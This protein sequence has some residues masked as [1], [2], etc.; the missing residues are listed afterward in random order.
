[1]QIKLD[2]SNAPS[3]QDGKKVN[4]RNFLKLGAASIV[5]LE[6]SRSQAFS[7]LIADAQSPLLFDVFVYGS[8]P[9]GVAAAWEAA[10]SGC[11][12]LLACPQNHPG[13]MLASGLCAMDTGGHGNLFGGFMVEYLQRVNREYQRILGP[14]GRKGFGGTEPSIA[15]KVFEDILG[16]QS[17][18]LQFFRRHHLLDAQVKDS[19]I[20]GVTLLS[21]KGDKI[22]VAARTF[23]DATYEADLA[24]CAKVPYRVG[25]EAREEYG[26]SKAGIYYMNTHTGEEIITPYSGESSPAI[27]A[28]CARSIF[29]DDSAHLV[30][31]EKPKTFEQH[32]PDYLPLLLDFEQRRITS[33]DFGKAIP[34]HK[35]EM[36]GRIDWQ[37][38]TNC[39]G[40]SWPWPEAQR[41]YREQLAQF[42][43]DHV[44]GLIWFLQN[45][46]GVPDHISRPIR[47]IGLHDSEFTD[48]GHWPWQI[49]VRQ[50]R[51]IE[52]RAI[53][54]Q[55]NFTPDPKTNKTPQ[56]EHPVAL[57]T[58]TFDV[59][60][61]QDRRF[62]VD[63]FMEGVLWYGGSLKHDKPTSPGQIPYAALLPKQLDNLLVP[64][65]LSS[66]HM[67]MAVVRMEPVWMT[68][69]HVAGFAAAMAHQKGMDV[70]NL[71]PTT[72]PGLL[73]IP[74]DPD[75]TPGA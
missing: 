8:T 53:V 14:G 73:K 61:C 24:A 21:P 34:R 3:L 46:P 23:I 25:R 7:D 52:G 20:T 42:H 11:R 35:Y 2:A 56:V 17:E 38:S 59:H 36:N 13:G 16:E 63:G 55:H 57:G 31:I 6:L 62:A 10:R 15:E 69:G 29:T 70:A 72:F 9:S 75:K 49:Y 54:T 74:I 48:N 40:I 44:A 4:R 64:V 66:T 65:G 50:G 41:F 26:E 37:T 33:W 67:G 12:V 39:P 1:M 22:Q 58:Y 71:D 60:P 51:R 5:A 43:V 47:A 68:T 30:P 19:R 18:R 45:Y 27:Q 28:Y 32:L